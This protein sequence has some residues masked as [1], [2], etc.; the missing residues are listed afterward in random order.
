VP[1]GKKISQ[2]SKTGF[3]SRSKIRIHNTGVQIQLEYKNKCKI[4]LALREPGAVSPDEM[5]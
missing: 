1:E 2:A 5:L 3:V 4:Y